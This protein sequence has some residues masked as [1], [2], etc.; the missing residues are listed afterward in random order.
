MKHA[1][2][3]GALALALTMALTALAGCG[4]KNPGTTVNPTAGSG[5]MPDASSEATAQVTPMDLSQV[6]DPFFAVSGLAGKE[7]VA[8]LGE[9]EISAADYLYWLNR[10]IDNYLSQFGGQMTTLPWDAEMAEGITFGQYM[11]DQ[12]MDAATFHCMLRELARQEGVS[13]DPSIALDM[14]KQ[15]AD[16]VVQAGSNEEQVIHTLWASMLTKDLLIRLNENSGLYDQLQELYFGENSG[17][18][19]TDAEVNAYLEES[20]QYRAKHILLATIDL[21]TRE[22]LDDATIAQKKATADDLLS[23]LRAAEDPVALFD[24]L[25]NEYSED[26]GLATNPDGY[27][28]QKGAMVE[29]FEN[30]ALALQNGEIS[31]V[32]ESDFGYHIILRLPMNPDDFRAECISAQMDELMSLEHERLGL[33]KTDA[34]TALDVGSFWNKML[35][36][37]AAVQAELAG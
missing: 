2:Q 27:T 20:G 12:A 26:S 8:K 28:T 30:A 31:E 11:Q 14:D 23:Q 13:P 4:S 5:S 6:T 7:V 37:R 22:P 25:M 3:F 18:Y 24:T 34:L 36:L 1:K 9:T 16:M 32:V 35:S 21:D 29:P 33:E 19:P 17:S 10:V 15:Y